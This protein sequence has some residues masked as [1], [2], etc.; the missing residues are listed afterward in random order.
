MKRKFAIIEA[1]SVLGLYS[2]G[3]ENLPDALL[4]AGLADC[5]GAR[6][7]ARVLSPPYNNRRD[8]GTLLLNGEGIADY[9]FNLANVVGDVINAGEFPV[10]IGGDC[11][12]LL[13]CLLA[14]KRRERHHGLLYL[15][16]HADF[17]QPSAEPN[18]EVASMVLALATGRGPAILSNLENRGALVKDEDVVLFGNRDAEEVEQEGSQRVEDT[19]INIMDIEKIRTSPVDDCARLAVDHLSQVENGFWVHTDADVLNDAMMPAVDYRVPGG[20]SWDE[21]VVTLNEIASSDKAIGINITIF[22]PN[23]D[24]DGTIAD[25]FTH[26]LCKG[27]LP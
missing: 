10:V 6:R 17:Y 27:L 26:S 11:S 1:P 16:G 22:N 21:L 13:G 5:L 12:I 9:S 20:L 14:V 18:G 3:V 19:S 2:S 7:V 25:A 4:A 23:L 24:K 15:D 8:P